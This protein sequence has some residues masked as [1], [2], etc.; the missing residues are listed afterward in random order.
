M[1][2]FR[3]LAIAAA[4][5]VSS[6]VGFSQELWQGTHEGMSSEEV[7]NLLP[8]AHAAKANEGHTRLSIDKV[9]IGNHSFAVWFSF[10]EDKLLQV[11][12][13]ESKKGL[14]TEEV[15]GL[16]DLLRLRYGEEVA[17]RSVPLGIYALWVKG[18]TT[19]ELK[20]ESVA[21]SSMTTITYGTR[22]GAEAA[23]L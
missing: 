12:L 21:S 4:L 11:V 19:I 17:S 8:D 9:I 18:K 13:A 1:N 23:K 2:L 5:V 6:Q 14:R 16:R 3:R 20:I 15:D 22:L 7:T 10:K